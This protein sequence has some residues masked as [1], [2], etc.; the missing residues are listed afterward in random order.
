M[1]KAHD[2]LINLYQARRARDEAK[3][4]LSNFSKTNGTCEPEFPSVPC[5][6]E[7]GLPFDEWCESCQGRQLIW[8]VYQK[9]AH[10]A[11]AALRT[12]LKYAKARGK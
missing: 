7:K 4:E 11:G 5:Y 9:T 12:C 1:D 10:K 8:K 2:L 6:I 3:K